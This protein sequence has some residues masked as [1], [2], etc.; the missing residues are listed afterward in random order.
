MMLKEKVAVI[1]GADGA[2]GAAVARAFTIEGALV[3][4]TGRRPDE[5]TTATVDALDER[6]VDRHMAMVLDR[7]GRVDISFNLI[8]IDHVQGV[9]LLDMPVD[10]FA[11]GIN[12]RARSHFITARAAARAMVSRG[13]GVILA[14][15]AAPDRTAIGQAGSFGIQCAAVESLIRTLA[16]EL[17]P[18][19]VRAACIRSAGSPDAAGVDEVF[20]LHAGNEGVSRTDYDRA[21]ARGTLLGRMPLLAEIAQIAVFL[22]SD[23][24]SALTATIVNATCGELLD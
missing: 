9:P 20:N 18:R 24:A 3:Q 19:G 14:L 22:A 12:Q 17:G 13:S 21:K 10:D 5:T 7:F 6:A 11:R 1:Y 15:T 8:G 16:V 4:L 2:V 23:R